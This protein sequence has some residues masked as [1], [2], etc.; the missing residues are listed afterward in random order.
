[1]PPAD[2]PVAP[3]HPHSG[4][5]RWDAIVVAGGRATRLGGIDKTALVFLGR[6]LLERVLDSVA[7]ADEVC[8]VGSN[9]ALP[10]RI[11][12]AV[13]QPRWGGPAAAVVAGLQALDDHPRTGSEPG[14]AADGT[15]DW[16]LV[17]AGDLVRPDQ[18]VSA[19]LAALPAAQAAGPEAVHG[20]ISVDADGRRQPL[21]AAYRRDALATAVATHRP[22]ENLAVKTLIS[23][24]NLLEVVLTDA[25]IDDVDTPDDAAR[26]G[27]TVPGP[28]SPPADPVA[29]RDA[30]PGPAGHRAGAASG[31]AEPPDPA[32]SE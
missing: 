32:P 11:L 3:G 8:V 13:E 18:A 16:I 24:L 23:G 14:R 21:L 29:A 6:T 9:Q 15:A 5:P 20:V 4:V 1:M 12:G 31:P 22:I 2:A 28:V 10:E 7:G 19:L 25:Q 27:I 17:L 26:L 30:A